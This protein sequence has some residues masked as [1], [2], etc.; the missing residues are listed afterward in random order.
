MFPEVNKSTEFTN[1]NVPNF[2]ITTM[3]EINK[4]E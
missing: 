1:K 4:G 2:D 3:E